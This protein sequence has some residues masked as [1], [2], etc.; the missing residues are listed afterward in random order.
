VSFTTAAN[1]F[2][3]YWGSGAPSVVAAQGSIYLRSDATGATSR[4]YVQGAAATA[5]SWVNV[6]MAA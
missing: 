1:N 3:I 4:L 6:T 5:A 2:G